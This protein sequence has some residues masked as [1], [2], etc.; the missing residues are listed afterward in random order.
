ISLKKA[1]ARGMSVVQFDRESNGAIDYLALA[2]EVLRTDGVLEFEKD[3]KISSIVKNID[4]VKKDRVATTS[5][6]EPVT[7]TT[8]S[9]VEDNAEPVTTTTPILKNT[10]EPKAP[11]TAPEETI[12]Q[13]A[14][15]PQST[16]V[17]TE[18]EKE[19]IFAI[20]A[21]NAKD[22]F[23]VGDFNHWKINDSSRLSRTAEGRWEK[24]IQLASGNKYKYKYVVDGEWTIDSDNKNLE[25]N[26]FGT[27]DSVIKL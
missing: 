1:A 5:E 4:D 9:P 15:P 16:I 24:R 17:D 27:F 22:I 11:E 20:N 25:Q 12:V 3:I 13:S 18:S 26:S 21:P 7:V 8:A 19:I 23:L 14:V 10:E 6:P 2:H